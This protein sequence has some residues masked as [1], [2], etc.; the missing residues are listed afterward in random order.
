[1][2]AEPRLHAPDV[3][4]VLQLLVEDPRLR[5]QLRFV[6]E[7]DR[8][9]SIQR[10]NLLVDGSRRENSAEH[11]WHQALMAMVL[12]EHAG[13]HGSGAAAEGA[14]NDASD[15][16]GSSLD[17]GRV[18]RMLLVHDLVEID[19]G[20]TFLYDTVGYQ[21]K[22]ARETAAAERIFGLLPADQ[23][24][25]LRALWDEFEAKESPEARFAGAVDRIQPLLHNLLTAGSQWRHYGVT[26]DRVRLA[27]RDVARG[28]GSLGAV[29]TALIDVAEQRG[30]LESAPQSDIQGDRPG[31]M[32]DAPGAEGVSGDGIGA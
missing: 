24:A 19:A 17:A 14:P 28:S 9:K 6:V 10:R 7:I 1:M 25:E 26:A 21:D 29:T 30:F 4:E 15:A 22:E 18:L 2:K 8:L 23:G 12:L 31:P 3:D 20:D 32:D 27:N 11:S 13:A 5:D 16:Q